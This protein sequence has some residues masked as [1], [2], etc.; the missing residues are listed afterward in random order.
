VLTNFQIRNFRGFKELSLPK[1]GRVNLIVG[2]NSV[3]KSSV[4]EALRIY[5]SNGMADVLWDAVTSRDEHKQSTRSASAA[6][7]LFGLFHEGSDVQEGLEIGPRDDKIMV[8]VL[9]RQANSLEGGDHI[10]TRAV[11]VVRSETGQRV[12]PLVRD[13]DGPR[14]SLDSPPQ[15]LQERPKFQSVF[16]AAN[17]VTHDHQAQLWDAVLLNSLDAD[18]IRSLRLILPGLE[19]IIFVGDKEG[20]GR[21]PF[22]TLEGRETP[23]P[24]RRLGDGV[25]RIFGMAMALV[26][27]QRGILLV[28]EI[29]NGIHY[30]VQES[31]W[32]F[33]LEI[34][35]RLNV[36]VFATS[37]SRDCLEAFQRASSECTSEEGI[38]TRLEQKNGT[39][40]V[41]QFDEP[42]LEIVTREQIEIR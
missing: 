12:L 39:I 38:V 5:A 32:K 31:L 20:H 11:V 42:E 3:G 7:A 33:I 21:S 23:V 28:D 29:E 30:S 22:V 40:V 41:S 2:K 17:G 27:A 13:L 36:Q 24:M 9:Y 34:S 14:W 4:L 10:D 26:N 18:V 6:Q 37:H 35:R 8:S 1:L 16:V 25:M 19:R 15:L